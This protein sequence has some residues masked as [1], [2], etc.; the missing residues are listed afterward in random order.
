MRLDLSVPKTNPATGG[1][2]GED[3]LLLS[4][5]RE[6]MEHALA[7]HSGRTLILSASATA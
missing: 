2:D 1:E 3:G 4:T 5:L 6:G 7:V